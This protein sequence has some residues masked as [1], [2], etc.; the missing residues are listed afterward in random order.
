MRFR[1]DTSSI[2]ARL[3]KAYRCL[4]PIKKSSRRYVFWTKALGPDIALKLRQQIRAR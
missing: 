2:A 1:R 3:A 4:I